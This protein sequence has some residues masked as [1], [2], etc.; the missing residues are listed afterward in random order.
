MCHSHCLAL[1]SATSTALGAWGH[2]GTLVHPKRWHFSSRTVP[3]G[4][5]THF[6][7]SSLVLGQGSHSSARQSDANLAWRTSLHNGGCSGGKILP[8]IRGLTSSSHL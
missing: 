1:P 2:G 6:G 4:P 8:S 7:G 5:V 3:P